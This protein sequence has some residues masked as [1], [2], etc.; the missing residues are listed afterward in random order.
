MP[1]HS[2]RLSPILWPVAIC[3]ALIAIALVVMVNIF[4]YTVTVSE[5][6]L[7]EAVKTEFPKEVSAGILRDPELHLVN[8]KIAICVTFEPSSDDVSHKHETVRLC[9]QGNPYWD[10]KHAAVYVR[11][12]ELLSTKAQWLAFESSKPLQEFLKTY[13]FGEMDDIMVYESQQL[14]GS[15]VDSVV[16]TDKVLRIRL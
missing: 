1:E 6:A 10:N 12:F 8:G 2:F 9:A 16:V 11:D 13:V 4:N 7:N 3:I 5:S 14:I 15:Q